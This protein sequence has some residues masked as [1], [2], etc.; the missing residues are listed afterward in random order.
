VHQAAVGVGDVGDPLGVGR[1]VTA[2]GLDARLGLLALGPGRGHQRG[3]PLLVAPLAGGR[4]GLQLR[5]GLAQ[6]GQPAGLAGQLGREL[7]ATPIAVLAVVALVGLGG[8][9]GTYTYVVPRWST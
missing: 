5:L 3:D 2:P 8:S 4:L 1:L 7:V 9:G 6:A